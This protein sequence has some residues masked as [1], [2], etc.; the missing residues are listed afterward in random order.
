MWDSMTRENQHT[1]TISDDALYAEII[2]KAK[3][4]NLSVPQLIW[5]FLHPKVETPSEAPKEEGKYFVEV[6]ERAHRILTYASTVYNK[7]TADMVEKL[8]DAPLNV[9]PLEDRQV[10][11]KE[12]PKGLEA[13]SN[14]ELIRHGFVLLQDLDPEGAEKCQT[15]LKEIGIAV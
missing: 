11:R 7:P 4:D 14:V 3:D 6:S 2:K 5:H 9:I 12:A 13:M 1:I 8:I 15:R 10:L